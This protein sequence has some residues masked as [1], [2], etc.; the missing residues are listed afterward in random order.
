MTKEMLKEGIASRA[1]FVEL[2]PFSR[3]AAFIW[4]D[5]LAKLKAFF[6]P[7]GNEYH[8]FSLTDF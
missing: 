5:L 4:P 2:F 8:S 1:S 7:Q 3:I 6:D